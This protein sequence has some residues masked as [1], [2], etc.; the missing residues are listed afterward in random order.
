MTSETIVV[1]CMHCSTKN[2]VA[3]SRMD[4]GPK[5]GKCGS[6]LPDTRLDAPVDI[7]DASFESEVMQSPVPVL[8]DCWA[9]WCGPCKTMGPVLDT[10][11]SEYRGKVKVA[12][13]NVDENQGTASRFSIMSIPTLLFVKDGQV[14]DTATGALPK[15]E[16]SGRMDQMLLSE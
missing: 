7:T 8:V 4:K 13:L 10:L 12:K 2:R 14:L 3:L 5:C 11:A 1:R 9:P 15:Q 6:S 16:I